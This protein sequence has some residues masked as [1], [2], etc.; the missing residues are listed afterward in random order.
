MKMATEVRR[1]RQIAVG[2]AVIGSVTGLLGCIL[3]WYRVSSAVIVGS[4][5]LTR[6]PQ[7]WE[8]ARGLIVLILMGATLMLA[9]LGLSRRVRRVAGILVIAVASIGGVLALQDLRRPQSGYI[10]F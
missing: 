4:T 9:L 2:L 7:G 1:P 3:P 5:R 10:D 6:L 8:T